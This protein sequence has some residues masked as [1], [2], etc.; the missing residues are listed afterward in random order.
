MEM[1]KIILNSEGEVTEWS[2][3]AFWSSDMYPWILLWIILSISMRCLVW[4]QE[5]FFSPN[6]HFSLG[7]SVTVRKDR[8]PFSLDIPPPHTHTTS[9]TSTAYCWCKALNAGI[10]TMLS[11]RKTAHP[12]MVQPQAYSQKGQTWSWGEYRGFSCSSSWA[13]DHQQERE[14]WNTL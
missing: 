1:Y 13:K 5:L 6:F 12:P 2:K 8:Q 3:V 9:T 11:L 14:L 10:P 7:P 4:S